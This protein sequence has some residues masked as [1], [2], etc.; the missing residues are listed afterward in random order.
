MPIYGRYTM[1]LQM[2]S[3]DLSTCCELLSLIHAELLLK[4]L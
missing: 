3:F 1:H 4:R 2:V